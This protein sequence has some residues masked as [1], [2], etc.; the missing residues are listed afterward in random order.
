MKKSDLRR[1]IREE[2]IN[3]IRG[4]VNEAFADPELAK[5]AKMRGIQAGRW[6]NFFRSFAKTHDIAWDKL[7]KGSF[8]KINNANEITT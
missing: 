6:Q 5:L 8:R 2:V 4:N 1:I 3:M 7:P